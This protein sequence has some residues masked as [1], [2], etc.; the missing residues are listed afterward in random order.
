MKEYDSMK[1][2]TKTKLFHVSSLWDCLCVSANNVSKYSVIACK[3]FCN[4][5]SVI[6]WLVLARDM[7][8]LFEIFETPSCNTNIKEGKKLCYHWLGKLYSLRRQKYWV[9]KYMKSTCMFKTMCVIIE[10]E[11]VVNIVI[12]R[13]MEIL[14]RNRWRKSCVEC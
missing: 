3:R 11:H 9:V 6:W 10:R 8:I 4:V 5:L 2:R 13:L 12:D 7:K 1:W 14:S